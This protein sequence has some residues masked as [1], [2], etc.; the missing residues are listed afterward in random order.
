MEECVED[1]CLGKV[2]AY[3]YCSKHYYV[4]NRKGEFGGEPCTGADCTSPGT[5][6]KGFCQ[7]HYAQDRRKNP[8]PGRE[9]SFPGCETG[10]ERHGLCGAHSAQQGRGEALRPVKERNQWSKWSVVTG[11][12]L[13]SWRTPEGGGGRERRMQHRH[14]MEE[15]LGRSLRKGENVHHLN[16]VRDDNRIENLELWSTFQP[17]GQRIQDKTDWAVEWLQMY[18]PEKLA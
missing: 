3:W 7:K 13:C 4:R 18:A 2:K 9:C 11:G 1:R 16:G 10:Y 5:F 6:S 17:K 8:P 12:Y 15:H 14:V